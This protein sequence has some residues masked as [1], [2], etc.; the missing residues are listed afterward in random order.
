M[1][2]LYDEVH[3]A[4][5]LRQ[6]AVACRRAAMCAPLDEGTTLLLFEAC[7]ADSEATMIVEAMKKEAATVLNRLLDNATLTAR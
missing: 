4:D 2:N 6:R 7:K 5:R 1:T 3:R